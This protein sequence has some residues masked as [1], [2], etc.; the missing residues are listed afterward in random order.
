[1]QPRSATTVAA[2]RESHHMK[3]SKI[4]CTLVAAPACLA[5]PLI[6]AR[7]EGIDGHAVIRTVAGSDGV[8]DGGA[9]TIGLLDTPMYIAFDA[10]GNCYI[11]DSYNA[12]IRKVD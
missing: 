3:P 11:A 4:H 2:Q 10:Q 1:L 7:A 12:R 9:A 8:I 5:L 6:P